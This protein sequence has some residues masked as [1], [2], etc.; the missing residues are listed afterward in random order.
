MNKCHLKTNFKDKNW[1]EKGILITRTHSSP[2]LLK[3]FA[4]LVH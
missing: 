1:K 4:A 2:F 3:E